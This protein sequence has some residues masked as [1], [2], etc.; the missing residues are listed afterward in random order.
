VLHRSVHGDARVAKLREH[1]VEV[2]DAVV[3]HCLPVEAAEVL[4]VRRKGRPDQRLA[5]GR[6]EH[7]S[8]PGLDVEPQLLGVPRGESRRIARAEED[9]TDSGHTLHR[10][11]PYDALAP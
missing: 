4:G 9:P 1:R 3:D 2:V 11:E 7:G 10:P 6:A 8:I 5:A